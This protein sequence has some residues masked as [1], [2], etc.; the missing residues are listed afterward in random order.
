M[1]TRLVK[2]Y[3][4]VD[5]DTRMGSNAAMFK[6]RYGKDALLNKIKNNGLEKYFPTYGKGSTVKKT[7]YS[8]G[9]MAFE[10]IKD[11]AEFQHDY[12]LE[13]FTE[14]VSV[15][16]VLCRNQRKRIYSSVGCYPERLAHRKGRRRMSPPQGTVFFD[17]VK[18][19]HNI[20]VDIAQ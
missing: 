1:R 17:W 19:G 16:G 15:E 14:I 2:G 10:T 4:V 11:A 20:A 9:I 13:D 3:K 5:R 18:V 8:L 12:G 6:R 7:D